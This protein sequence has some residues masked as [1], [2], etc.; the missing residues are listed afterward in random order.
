MYFVNSK[1]QF[2][3]I[4][5]KYLV[6]TNSLQKFIRQDINLSCENCER[7]QY[8][9]KIPTICSW[10][11]L[12][13]RM[14]W[15]IHILHYIWLFS[16]KIRTQPVKIRVKDFAIKHD[17]SLSLIMRYT[18]MEVD[19]LNFIVDV[20]CPQCRAYS[21]FVRKQSMSIEFH[22]RV[23]AITISFSIK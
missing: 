21:R 10:T 15:N 12:G 18:G 1:Q 3:R 14:F 11:S 17:R 16:M 5:R 8:G 22:A 19:V 20:A 6:S 9:C 2:P 13:H 4:L 23:A 7:Q